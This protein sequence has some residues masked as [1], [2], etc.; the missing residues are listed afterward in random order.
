[1]YLQKPIQP[2]KRQ[3]AKIVIARLDR[4]SC[5]VSFIAGILEQGVGLVCAEMLNAT[6]FQLHIFA[7]LARRSA[8]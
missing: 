6:A 7:A 2:A 4:S 3:N 1:M 5:R 8:D